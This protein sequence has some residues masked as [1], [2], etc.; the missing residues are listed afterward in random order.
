MLDS[1]IDSPEPRIKVPAMVTKLT[2]A[3]KNEK[4]SAEDFDKASHFITDFKVLAY[5]LKS[6]GK[7][8]LADLTNVQYFSILN[9]YEE[10]VQKANAQ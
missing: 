8:S 4:I 6:Y 10:Y 9:H 7:D 1:E 3:N 5:I 2:D